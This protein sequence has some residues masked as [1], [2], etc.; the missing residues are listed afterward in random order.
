MNKKF[1]SLFCASTVLMGAM[2]GCGAAKTEET[3]PE[4]EAATTAPEKEEAKEEVKEDKKEEK[5]EVQDVKLKVWT[6]ENQH[7]NGTIQAMGESFQALHP[8]YNIEFTYEI[9]GEDKVKDEILKDASSAADV[10]FFANDQMVELV[11]AG[12]LAKLGGSTLDMINETMTETV[13]DTV[14]NP[15]DNAVYGIPFTHNTFFA[16]YDKS[17]M[18][19]E[20]VKTIEG[21]V[22][23][24]TGDDVTNYFFESAG[25]WKLGAWYY[26]AGNTIYGE[27][28]NDFAAGADWNNE[29]GLAVTNYL[30]DLAQ[31]PK[32]GF[33][34]E[35]SVTERISNNTLGVWFDGAWNYDVYHDILGDNL[36]L[37]VLPTFEINGEAKQLKGFYGSKAIGV[38]THSENLPVAVQFAAYL[39]SEEMQVKR[40]EESKQVPTN[41]K[42]SQTES[43]LA[44]PLASI[45]VKEV[46]VASVAQPVA[47]EFGSR[48]WSNV[49]ALGTEIK[50]GDLN[51]DNAQA[52]LDTFVATMEVK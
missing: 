44:D 2:T 26:G 38:N 48:Y 50:S 43:V 47:A 24:E 31:N 6:P 45:I 5:V 20:D 42:A 9:I 7:A 49:G 1:I 15:N 51:K 34:N 3:V 11:N 29:T 22:S 40:Y 18:T 25:G 41:I 8:E 21:I 10:F 30:I 12:V 32:V 14:T 17:L 28:Q 16:Y 37:A 4:K 46:E 33:D 13:V 39:G 19:E 27:S 23:K 35:I 36:G 52:K